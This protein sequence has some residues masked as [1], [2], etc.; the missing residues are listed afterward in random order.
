MKTVFRSTITLTLAHASGFILSL[1]E[2]L[3]LARVL[4][5][6]AY[7]SLLWVQA[8]AL[9]GSVLVEWGFNLGATREVALARND[10]ERLK[11][12]CGD[13]FLAKTI[14][15]MI[16]GST[17]VLIYLAYKPVPIDLAAAGLI[18]LIGFGM[19]PFWY[20]QGTEK[21]GRAVVAEIATRVCALAGLAWLI[22]TPQDTT[23]ALSLMA[24]GGLS[25]TL[26]STML[27][28]SEV[29]EFKAS[30]QGSLEQV[31][32]N[33]S[34]FIYKGS[35]ALMTTAV[36]TI[37]GAVAGKAAVGVFAPAEKFVKALIG[38]SLP[39]LN[40]FYPHLSRLFMAD[41]N[42]KARQ[43][44]LLTIV[45]SSTGL[46]A[47]LALT[48]TGP[49]LLAWLLGPGYQE[50]GALLLL[51]IWLIPLRLLNQTLGF[52]FLLPAQVERK[53][54]INMLVASFA[55]LA[56]G[57]ILAS[58]HGAA[59]MIWAMLVGEVG[60]AAVQLRMSQHLLSA[61]KAKQV[62]AK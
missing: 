42:R 14:L 34:I 41:R 10:P 24:C 36:T 7:G 37:L 11:R 17:F 8:S 51:M 9:L 23:L 4:G 39:V 43:A 26:I 45:T 61:T 56:I 50:S 40:A 5:P 49:S 46:L 54:S 28:R 53:A 33:T 13:I 21:M 48:F 12:I 35:S 15:L 57:G 16:V 59:G 38:L 3:I 22:K 52:A 29:G 25:C 2:I 62:H 6:E 47:A 30:L 60:L 31:R 27:C 55:T 58:S 1:A 19:S 18:Y 32:K 44:L 20:F